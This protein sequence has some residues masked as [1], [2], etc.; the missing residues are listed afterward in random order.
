MEEE[1]GIKLAAV[2]EAGNEKAKKNAPPYSGDRDVFVRKTQGD[3]PWTPLSEVYID[4]RGTTFIFLH[5]PC[6]G[7]ISWMIF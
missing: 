3:K 4:L 7:K 1:K 2:G 5:C 6:Q